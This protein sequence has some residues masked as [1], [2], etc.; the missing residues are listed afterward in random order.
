LAVAGEVL[1]RLPASLRSLWEAA[2]SG[3]AQPLRLATA[4]E[5]R[6]LLEEPLEGLVRVDLE[7][8][9]RQPWLPPGEGAVPREGA[10]ESTAVDAPNPPKDDS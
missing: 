5:Q 9:R 6:L 8:E 1:P 3:S 2:P 4:Q 10:G 7:V